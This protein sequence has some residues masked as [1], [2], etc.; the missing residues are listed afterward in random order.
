MEED[1]EDIEPIEICG[2]VEEVP[3]EE[4]NL[5]NTELNK[6]EEVA[7]AIERDNPDMPMDKKMAIATA[8]AKKS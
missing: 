2:K 1:F 8:T 5:T 7:Q 3:I 4:R 6:R